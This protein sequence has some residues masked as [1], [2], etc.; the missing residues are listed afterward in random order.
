MTGEAIT[1]TAPTERELE[2]L[3]ILWDRGEAT[4]RG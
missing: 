4:V 1:V 3:K 2:I